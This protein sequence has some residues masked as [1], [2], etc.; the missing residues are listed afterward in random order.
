MDDD[1]EPLGRKAT[2]PT[3]DPWDL[4]FDRAS[5]AKGA[6]F[7]FIKWA[8]TAELKGP[9]K[10]VL[11]ALAIRADG[12][13]ECWP[14]LET[15]SR[16]SGLARATVTRAIARLENEGWIEVEHGR[17]KGAKRDVNRYHIRMDRA[18]F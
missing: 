13:G 10:A 11:L 4:D 14:E 7:T 17:R 18:P 9:A 8:L 15:L 5:R 2:P 1:T 16:D 3:T 12:N 6:G